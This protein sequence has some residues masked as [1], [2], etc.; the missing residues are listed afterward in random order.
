MIAMEAFWLLVAAHTFLVGHM[1]MVFDGLS[2]FSSFNNNVSSRVAG[3][4]DH[5]FVAKLRIYMSMVIWGFAFLGALVRMLNKKKDASLVILALMPFPLFIAQPYGGE[6]LL[7]S[8]LFALPAMV[9][10]AASLF[11]SSPIAALRRIPVPA[12]RRVP[13]LQRISLSFLQRPV[14]QNIALVAMNLLLISGFL[15]T[16]YGNERDDYMTYAEFAGVS[17]LYSIAPAHSLFMTC[18]LG[19]PWQ[20][21]DYE[22][23][24]LD[25]LG[26]TDETTNDI[27]NVNV[28]DIVKTMQTESAGAN[29]YLI[30]TRSEIA[31]FNATSGLPPGRLNT[32][33]SAVSKSG[34]FSLIYRNTDVQIYALA[35]LAQGGQ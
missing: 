5:T 7:R 10:F 32:L 20:Y 23:Y 13:A 9:F 35:S 28:P 26:S 19:G 14:W 2:I 18:W 11:Y 1:S 29:A 16:R 6:M 25:E 15:F 3:N 33:E 21:K 17:H 4:A 12:L 34:D 31:T 30:F 22:K 27:Q 8:Y 24:T